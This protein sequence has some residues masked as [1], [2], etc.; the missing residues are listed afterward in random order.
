MRKAAL[1]PLLLMTAV[2]L[3]TAQS[4]Q[5]KTHKHVAP[6][7]AQDATT[8]P[9]GHARASAKATP[10]ADATDAQPRATKRGKHAEAQKQADDP[11]SKAA[12]KRG[13][14]VAQKA[15][16][17]DAPAPAV[18]RDK[19]GRVIAS[20]AAPDDDA[21]ASA[22]TTS[23]NSKKKKNARA[24]DAAVADA[25]APKRDKHGRL[26]APKAVPDDDATAAAPAPRRGKHARTAPQQAQDDAPPPLPA[27]GK[28]GRK[29]AGSYEDGYRA[30][31]AAALAQMRASQPS[32]MALS[33]PRSTKPALRPLTDD[34][35]IPA[36]PA[37]GTDLLEK[38]SIDL[39]GTMP[40]PLK[41]STAS[42][43][44]QN[45]R[46]IDDGLER[47]EDDHD[48]ESRIAHKLLVP[49]PTSSMLTINQD[50]PLQ[51]RYCRPW[52]ARFLADLA[53]LHYQTFHRPLIV[54][55]AVRTVDYQKHLMGVNGN[56]ARA[57]G[58]I[59]S[60]H[61]TG[62]A[63]DLP[64]EIFSRQEMAWMRS[65]LAALQEAG[66]IDVE[67][68]FQQ[69]CFHIS[70][71]KSYMTKPGMPDDTTTTPERFNANAGQ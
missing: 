64:K 5:A 10:A 37:S 27:R 63:V 36:G 23:K 3:G 11:P 52:T 24:D 19:H 28:R 38:T 20:K 7:A 56:A 16:E 55:S 40:A 66:K 14:G 39:R 69:T 71:Y 48:L 58:D 54:S 13:R 1:F 44:R 15:A 31:F 12:S 68:E 70:V 29:P 50:I 35:G 53:R 60:P 49:V 4:A 47:I 42:L 6:D 18:K 21:A 46:L 9:R 2:V 33:L 17:D 41:G 25:P 67:E 59:V 65:K 22:R 62:A 51:R 57:E 34:G 43:V 26:I 8:A 32:T 30:G 45:T 61:L